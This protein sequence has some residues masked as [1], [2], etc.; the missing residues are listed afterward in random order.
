M[1]IGTNNLNSNHSAKCIAESVVEKA[2]VLKSEKH[3][4]SLSTIVLRKVSLKNKVNEVNDHLKK[5]KILLI[6]H[7]NSTKQSHIIRTRTNPFG[8]YPYR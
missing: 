6:D 8:I 5:T 2:L 3:D 1:W 7:S 4:I